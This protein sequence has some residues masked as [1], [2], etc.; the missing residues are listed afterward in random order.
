MAHTLHHLLQVDP[1]WV[2]ATVPAD[3]LIRYA[4]RFDDFRLPSDPRKRHALAETIGADGLTLLPTLFAPDTPSQLRVVPAVDVLRRIWLQQYW[5]DHGTVRWR[6]EA[7][8]PPTAQLIVSPYDPDA[9]FGIKRD[10]RWTGYKAHV[11]ETCDTEMP[12]L[13]T[14]VATTPATTADVELTA[15]IHDALAARDLAPGEHLV[16][17]GYVDSELIVTSRTAHQIELLGPVLPDTSWQAR[18][19]QGFDSACFRVDW[20]A[21][22]VTCPQGRQ[23]RSWRPGHNPD[24]QAIID[25][26]FDRADC[27]ACAVRPQCTKA[28]TRPRTMKLHPQAQHEALQAARRQQTTDAFKQRYARRAGVEGTLA[29][30]VRRC[31]LRQ[32]RYRGLAKTQTP[33]DLVVKFEPIDIVA[34]ILRL[35]LRPRAMYQREIKS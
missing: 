30:G 28:E 7:D 21:Q 12:N 27:A 11:T 22:Q 2:R 31:D 8:L 26:W 35:V 18:A 23:S 9:R 5:T 4:T 34:A 32:A 29:Q 15:A 6:Q 24:G 10:I 13:I 19:G 20:D 33:P 3:W 17:T 25:V 1:L 14:H 16:D